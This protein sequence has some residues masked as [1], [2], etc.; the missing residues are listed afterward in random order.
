MLF[1]RKLPRYLFYTSLKKVKTYQKLKSRGSCLK[2]S[3]VV[4]FFHRLSY[5]RGS[6]RKPVY[7]PPTHP[8]WSLSLCYVNCRSGYT[9]K[10]QNRLKCAAELVSVW[11]NEK[12][13]LLNKSSMSIV[14]L[15]S[16]IKRVR[17]TEILLHGERSLN[18]FRAFFQE[19]S[20]R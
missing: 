10:G 9:G 12:L 6:G 5:N 20:V 13:Q 2:F 18:V 19:L 16:F 4:F 11:S 1:L 7:C 8:H 15:I 14:T 17:S 3:F